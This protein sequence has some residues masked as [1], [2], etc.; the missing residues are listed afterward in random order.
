M[1]FF[2]ILVLCLLLTAKDPRLFYAIIYFFGTS[3]SFFYEKIFE[4]IDLWHCLPDDPKAYDSKFLHFVRYG[5]LIYIL[6]FAVILTYSF[7]YLIAIFCC[8]YND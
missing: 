2:P 6:I 8:K 5:L 4:G 3:I 1:L 7:I